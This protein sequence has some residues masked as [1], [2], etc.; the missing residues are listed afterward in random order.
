MKE[1]VRADARPAPVSAQV[2]L[3]SRPDF[4]L[5]PIHDW[6][7]KPPNTPESEVKA[8]FCVRFEFWGG[9]GGPS[10]AVLLRSKSTGRRASGPPIVTKT[11]RARVPHARS[12]L[13]KSGLARNPILAKPVTLCGPRVR[14]VASVFQRCGSRVS[15][16][17]ASR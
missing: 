7:A 1:A 2:G 9:M 6:G 16:E 12:E 4:A 15:I 8:L 10:L 5:Y 13:A 14:S 17:C 3:A 11:S